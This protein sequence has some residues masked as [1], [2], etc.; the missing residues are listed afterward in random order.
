MKPAEIFEQVPE[1]F[2]ADKAGGLKA[3]FQFSLSGEDGGDWALK[4]ADGTCT[5]IEGAVEN[6]SV[7]IRMTA[8]DYVKMTTGE[9]Q[10]VVAF[11]QGKIRMQ[12]DMALAM[13]L[14]E[15]FTW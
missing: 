7:T 5:V 8:A 14:Q 4:V 2:Q 1:A 6:P 12:G 9:L 15:L 3:T 10:P 13:Q 11:M